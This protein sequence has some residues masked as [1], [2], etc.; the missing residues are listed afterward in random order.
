[1]SKTLSKRLMKYRQQMKSIDHELFILIKKRIQLSQKIMRYKKQLG[2]KIVDPAR[3]AE[4]KKQ[5]L[6]RLKK[7]TTNSRASDFIKKLMKLNSR[8]P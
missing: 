3:E 8:Y 2:L 1:M 7:L 6:K 5:L 4:I